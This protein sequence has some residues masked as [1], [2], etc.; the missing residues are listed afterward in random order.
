M[1]KI[2][3]VI[4]TFLLFS[5]CFGDAQNWKSY[6]ANILPKKRFEVGLFQPFRYGYSETLEYSTYP[7]W[8]F[9]MPNLTLKKSH[10]KFSG[11]NMASKWS[12]FYPRPILNMVSKK[13]IGGFIDPTID[14]PMM[15]GFSFSLILTK[16]MSDMDISFNSGIDIGL[17]LDDLDDRV[18]IELPLLYHRLSVFHNNYGFH[19]GFD[20][21]KNITDQFSVLVDLDFSILPGMDT[22]DTDSGITKLLGE[23]SFEHKAL[24]IYR[25]SETFRLLTGYK[26]VF[27]EYPFG[28]ESRLLPFLPLVD[29]WIPMIEL[30]WGRSLK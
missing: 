19:T 20:L 26:F 10:E 1:K 13:G 21:E 18:N 22:K 11:Y 23:Y 6:S 28:P 14:I 29:S 12:L 4:F 17:A 9:V 25:K 15:L 8:F 7:L 2:R 27:G 16:P 3:K 30:Q 5:I 24:L